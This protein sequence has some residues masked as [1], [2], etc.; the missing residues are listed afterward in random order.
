M[1]KFLLGLQ[2]GCYYHRCSLIETA[3][4]KDELNLET[5]KL[6]SHW[7]KW[8]SDSGNERTGFRH[9]QY[10]YRGQV[11]VPKPKPSPFVEL[12]PKPASNC[13][14]PAL[15]VSILHC[16][17]STHFFFLHVSFLLLEFNYTLPFGRT[18]AQFPKPLSLAGQE[19][20]MSG[21]PWDTTHIVLCCAQPAWA[22]PCE[23]QPEMASPARSP[24]F[25][26]VLLL[27]S[28]LI[29]CLVTNLTLTERS[30]LLLLKSN[31][32]L[33]ATDGSGVWTR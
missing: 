23:T 5:F 22:A 30:K 6:Q 9:C 4:I 20:K 3:A 1:F 7:N 21:C 29:F 24:D 8:S 19:N 31:I 28:L 33:L 25:W 13:P 17:P 2:G 32:L 12:L 27:A 14:C 18:S 15:L 10:W 11:K 26:N 16:S